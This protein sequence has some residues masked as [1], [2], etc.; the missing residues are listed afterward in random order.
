MNNSDK[1]SKKKLE[2]LINAGKSAVD[3]LLEE[4]QKP[5]DVELSDEKRRNAIKAK[6]ECFI[7]C[8]EIL[9]SIKE[10]EVKIY[11][12]GEDSLLKREAD[13]EASFAER[14]AKR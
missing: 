8:E 1:Y 5:L 4:I 13:F 12:D 7:D 2:E 3:I 6:K 14:K 10:L 9:L 11:G